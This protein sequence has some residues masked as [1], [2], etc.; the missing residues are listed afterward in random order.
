M[1]NGNAL[2]DGLPGRPPAFQEHEDIRGSMRAGRRQRVAGGGQ[3]PVPRRLSQSVI[4]SVGPAAAQ[5]VQIEYLRRSI[6]RQRASP[7]VQNDHS[8][9]WLLSHDRQIM[10][11]D[12]QLR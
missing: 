12:S 2:S 7:Y 6:M 5:V 11:P 1:I 4:D 3:T 8:G 9:V 10:S